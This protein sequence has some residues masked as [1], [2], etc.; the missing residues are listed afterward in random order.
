MIYLQPLECCL[1]PDNECEM[2][3]NVVNMHYHFLSELRRF[4]V[5]SSPMQ[6][7]L[8]YLILCRKHFYFISESSRAV[9][10]L[11]S[12]RVCKV[13]SRY[14]FLCILHIWHV[15]ISLVLGFI[16]LFFKLFPLSSS[17]QVYFAI[18]LIRY[19]TPARSCSSLAVFL[20]GFLVLLCYSWPWE[21]FSIF[22]PSY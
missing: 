12:M 1:S 17:F 8:W 20:I 18:L 4:F 10:I 22:Q 21:I 16:H 11:G 2:C 19:Q 15:G 14:R 6:K 7:S 5:L 9:F 13:L 3:L